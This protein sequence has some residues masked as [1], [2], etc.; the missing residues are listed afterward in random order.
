MSV[1]NIKTFRQRV[2]GFTLVELLTVITI[3]AT[4]IY[5]SLTFINPV[6]QLDRIHDAKRKEDVA[7]IK[8]ALDLYYND[9]GCYPASLD[10]GQPWI[11]SSVT[12]MR[13]IPQDSQCS[14]DPTTC[15]IYQHSGSTCPDWSVLFSKLSTTPSTSA[16]ILSSLSSCV[17][18]DFDS[19][20]ACTVLGN[21]DC[22]YLSSL[23]LSNG[24]INSVTPTPT[25]VTSVTPLPTPTPTPESCP[26]KNYSCTGN[27]TSC[28]IVPG[29]TGTYC[30]ET[31]GGACQ[32]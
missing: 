2:L 6:K 29:G 20:W 4:L 22:T 28:N 15:Y 18:V 3:L 8:I 11:E 25:V 24:S 1:F 23:S 7:Q 30:T 10:F 17:P 21:V 26:V 14:S 12:Y 27:P 9:N 13:R 5:L 16:C 31:C 32:R 19:T